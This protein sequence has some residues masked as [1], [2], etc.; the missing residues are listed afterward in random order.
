MRL[1]TFRGGVKPDDAKARTARA[2]ITPLPAPAEVAVPM[3]QHIGAPAR[4]CVA[5]GDEVL[6]GQVVGEPDGFVSAAVHA[7]VS[8]RVGAVEPRPGQLGLPVSCVV[9]ENDGRDRAAE[10]SGL[11][12]AWSAADPGRIRDLVAAA[13]L[14]GMGGAAFPTHVKLSPPPDRPI[15]AVILNGAEC[16]PYLTADHRI[17]LER[18]T[19]VLAGLAIVRRVLGAKRAVVGI[20]ENKPDAIAAMRDAAEDAEI[21]IAVL[22]KKY[23][24][25]AEKQLIDAVLG[26]EVP[27]GGLPMDV[28]CVVQNVG[29]AAAVADAVIRGRP[30]FERVVTVTG[31]PVARP[32]NMLVRVGTPVAAVIEACGGD[33]AGTAKLVLGG[34]MMGL[35]QADTAATVTKGTSG[36]LLLGPAEVD[37]GP[38]SP[39]IRCGRCVT[40]CPIRL[41]PTEIGNLAVRGLLED[42]ERIGIMDCIECGSC[43]FACPSRIPLAQQIRLG[44]AGILAARRGKGRG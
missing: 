7:P 27:A 30:L 8:G 2:A 19:D 26:R 13:G 24:Q 14:V 3:S 32:A 31:S 23:P 4:P 38:P 25:G 6:L 5:A 12:Q 17:M 1:L 42:A 9:I 40:A 18:A 36:I 28:G 34:P 16:E 35:A 37:A 10:F 33:L 41:V 39:C 22:A 11:G 29:T 20:E 43:A 21:E 44:K 15:D